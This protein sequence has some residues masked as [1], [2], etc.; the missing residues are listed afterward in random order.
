MSLNKA[1]KARVLS[2]GTRGHEIQSLTLATALAH[3]HQINTISVPIP[4]RWALPHHLPGLGFSLRHQLPD[5]AIVPQLIIST[6]RQMAGAGRWL[7][8]HQHQ[9]AKHIHILNPGYYFSDID[10]VLIPEHDHY[11]YPRAIQFRGNLHPYNER[12]FKQQP[13]AKETKKTR[14]AL[15]IGN[16][17]KAYFNR[18]F[19]TDLKRIHDTFRGAQLTIC[20]SP[21]LD[22]NTQDYIRAIKGA[23]DTMWLHPD[24]GDN[25]YQK[26]LAQA[27][28]IFVTADSINMMNEAGASPAALTL[29]AQDFIKSK[30]HHRFMRSIN[31]R[32]SAFDC[33]NKTR[34]LPD[35]VTQLLENSDLLERLELA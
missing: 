9:Q 8:K 7:K 20:G 21:R 24:D 28:K 33:L 18:Q 27:D 2:E 12:W 14:L 25:P 11:R 31:H 32:L 4:W 16:P 23:Q 34:A 15:F 35:P 19:K 22:R 10:L 3:Q 17:G 1:N 30:K 26:L 13:Q 29:L 6:G 5:L